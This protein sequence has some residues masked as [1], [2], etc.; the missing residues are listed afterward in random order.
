M[1]VVVMRPR[2]ATPGFLRII[3]QG[4]PM[5]PYRQLCLAFAAIALVVLAS[6]TVTPPVPDDPVAARLQQAEELLADGDLER[7]AMIYRE[8][9]ESKPGA[10]GDDLR[11]RAVE[12]LLTADTRE[13]AREYLAGINPTVLQDDLLAR[14]RLAEASLAIL[15]EKPAD[16]LQILPGDVG[17]SADL[18]ARILDLRATALRH[19]GELLESVR[20]RMALANMLTIPRRVQDNH[21]ALWETLAATE[22]EELNEWLD[23]S[24][25][26]V[27]R[28]WLA[29]ASIGKTT[30]GRS[31]ALEEQLAI[32]QEH[33]PQHPAVPDIVERLREDWAALGTT[34]GYVAITLPMNGRYERVSKAIMTGIMAAYYS[35]ENA[36]ERPQL[37][38]YDSSK[39]DIRSVYARAVEDGAELVI[40]P[41]SKEAVDH[42]ARTTELPVPVLS[43]NYGTEENIASENFYQFG[44]LPEDEAAQAAERA[45]A[46]GHR[47]AVALVPKGAWGS[48]LLTAFRARFEELGGVLLD[49]GH[50]LASS[51]DYSE[52]IKSVLRLD[53]SETR[54]LALDDVLGQTTG[55][56]PRRRQ[57][58]DMVFIAAAP[59]QARLIRPQLKFHYA[60]DLPVYATSHIY[61]G[62]EDTLADEDMNG[63][64]YCEIP[65]S[66]GGENPRPELRETLDSLFP[67]ANRQLPR[68]TALGA[69]AYGLIPVYAR[70]ASQSYERY[71]GLTGELSMDESRRIHRRLKWARFVAGKP[72]PFPAVTVAEKEPSP[73]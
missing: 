67:E 4:L 25:D 65:W 14:H 44:L 34:P 71:A 66:L 7:A 52:T 27:L 56:V 55:F 49:A 29:L 41:L 50:Y 53:R 46:D 20:M 60:R 61:T 10:E 58:A 51:A 54:H 6:C 13:R 24:E 33:Y 36:L 63:I 39:A 3:H 30:P 59:R 70:L 8:V 18:R 1:L 11:L 69:D 47:Y 42:L 19:T 32:W 73:R 45:W 43:L 16:A 23:A 21:T 28:G 68:L 26:T 12:V 64:I 40:G 22:E 35:D 72:Q 38:V 2:F 31:G 17:L 62:L 57:D 9:G 5:T 15:E 37:S 48:R